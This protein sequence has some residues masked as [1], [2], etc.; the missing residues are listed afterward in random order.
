MYCS[1]EKNSQK[2]KEESYAMEFLKD[3]APVT[4]NLVVTGKLRI[5]YD[6]C[7]ATI[8]PSE[9]SINKRRAY[10]RSVYQA[11]VAMSDDV[12]EGA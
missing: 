8:N 9:M 6:I 5:R 3:N 12:V 1:D 4:F 7:V 11:A 2:R 10:S